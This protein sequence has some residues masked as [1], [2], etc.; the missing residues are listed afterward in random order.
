MTNATGAGVEIPAIERELTLA[1]SPQRVESHLRP[2][3]ARPLVPTARRVGP[4]PG[5]HGHLLVGRPRQL[6][7]R[8]RGRR[9]A[10][11][12]GVDLGPRGGDRSGEPGVRHA[13]RV[14]GRAPRRRWRRSACVSRASD[15]PPIGPGTT[16]AGPRSSASS[17]P[18]LRRTPE[19]QTSQGFAGSATS[20]ASRTPP[21]RASSPTPRRRR[22]A[23]V[24]SRR[25][26]PALVRAVPARRARWRAARV[27]PRPR[28]ASEASPR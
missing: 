18:C 7:D 26:A 13:S 4:A 3:R 22:P 12:P 15:S 9:P 5:W 11:L 27:A 25:S 1:A 8:G 16:R 24:R 10:A 19:D 2:H 21:R 17:W 20:T 14:V 23:D 28:R 6:P